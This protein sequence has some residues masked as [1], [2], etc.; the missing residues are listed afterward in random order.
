[1]SNGERDAYM[2]RGLTTSIF[3]IRGKTGFGTNTSSRKQIFSKSYA[4][5]DQ[6]GGF[7]SKN[8]SIEVH[9]MSTYNEPDYK[10]SVES[11]G[12]AMYVPDM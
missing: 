7:Y 1:M 8:K 4:S 10:E 5:K 9:D 6:F 11:V 12:G 2:D 3:Q